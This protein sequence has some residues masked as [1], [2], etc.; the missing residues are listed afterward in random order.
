MDEPFGEWLIARLEAYREEQEL[1][2]TQP[3]QEFADQVKQLRLQLGLSV[4][5]F[6]DRYAIPTADIITAELSRGVEPSS[7]M[8][9]MIQMIRHDPKRVAQIVANARARK[10]EGPG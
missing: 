9:L 3:T 7:G 10:A 5:E 8:K 1:K 6:G 2:K 4:Q